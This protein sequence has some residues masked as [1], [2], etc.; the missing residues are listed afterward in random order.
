MAQLSPPPIT[1]TSW[2]FTMS[3]PYSIPIPKTKKARS[4]KLQL[5]GALNKYQS[6][7]PL[8]PDLKY[9][10][11][12]FLEK[13]DNKLDLIK[14]RRNNQKL[15]CLYQ[16]GKYLSDHP[17]SLKLQLKDHSVGNFLFE[18]FY[19][20]EDAI[21]YLEDVSIHNIYYISTPDRNIILLLKPARPVPDSPRYEPQ[22]P[23]WFI[24]GDFTFSPFNRSPTPQHPLGE[25]EMWRNSPITPPLAR[26][27]HIDD[28]EE[29]EPL[30][31]EPLF[32]PHSLQASSSLLSKAPNCLDP[33]GADDRSKQIKRR[34]I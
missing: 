15:Q 21:L 10:D 23:D 1:A 12:D 20:E 11:R 27:H 33:Q 30:F 3:T 9:D 34:R 7:V 5:D 13:L 29:L 8:W 24:D 18:Y 2:I 4:L 17:E 6:Q 25:S 19:G 26:K 22:E 31:N 16:L 32:L 14:A 28:A